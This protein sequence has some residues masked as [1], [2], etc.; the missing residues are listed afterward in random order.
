MR[1]RMRMKMKIPSR[2]LRGGREPT[3]LCSVCLQFQFVLFLQ[4]AE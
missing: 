4:S 1:M 2:S 3:R